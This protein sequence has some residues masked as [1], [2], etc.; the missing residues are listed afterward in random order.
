MI[1]P[2]DRAPRF[3]DRV[4]F[5]AWAA[6][7]PRGRWERQDG[8]VIA[9]AP[10][11][12]RHTMVKYEVWQA[13]RT[14]LRNGDNDCR[15][16]GDGVTVEIDAGTDDEPD[17]VV[18]CGGKVNEE[19]MTAENPVIIVEV[20]SPSTANI[21]ATAKLD[22]YF[23]LQSVRHYLL[24]STE[25]AR[26]MHHRRQDKGTFLTSIHTKGQIDLDPPGIPVNVSEFYQDTE[27][28]EP[29]QPSEF[30]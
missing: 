4:A 1:K 3:M 29:A 26:V 25:A 21:D 13:F 10:E 23:R 22:N 27:L 11:R 19:G 15:V 7:Q 5:R 30:P 2:K 8:Q 14:A 17:M 9:M 6:A 28:A 18:T 24:V 16:I 20:L 12:V